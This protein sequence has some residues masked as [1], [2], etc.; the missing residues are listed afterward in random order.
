MQIFDVMMRSDISIP[1]KCKPFSSLVINVLLSGCY[2]SLTQNAK[3]ERKVFESQCFK[4]FKVLV[5]RNLK[6][7]KKKNYTFYMSTSQHC[8][9]T[10]TELVWSY[11]ET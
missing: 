6:K 9:K 2:S 11:C 7:K 1:V 5:P 3:V 8:E 10:K 4:R